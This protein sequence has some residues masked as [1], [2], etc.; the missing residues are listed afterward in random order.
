MKKARLKVLAVALWISRLQEAER[1]TSRW[2]LHASRLPQL[3]DYALPEIETAP[4][5]RASGLARHIS[6]NPTYSSAH[7]NIVA[8]AQT[9]SV[10]ISEDPP[11]FLLSLALIHIA[12]SV[13]FVGPRIE[14]LSG[15]KQLIAGLP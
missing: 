9:H 7:S 5:T 10:R 13:A 4:C 3:T 1:T 6:R 8:L 15:G 2:F 12:L 11:L 14:I